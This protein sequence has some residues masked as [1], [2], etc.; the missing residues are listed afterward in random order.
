MEKIKPVINWFTDRAS[1][2]I[3][4]SDGEFKSVVKNPI[5][6]FDEVSDHCAEIGA[7]S[8]SDELFN[9]VMNGGPEPASWAEEDNDERDNWELEDNSKD[10]CLPDE[11]WQSA[12]NEI[13]YRGLQIFLGEIIFDNN[14]STVS[15]QFLLDHGRNDDDDNKSLEDAINELEPLLPE[16]AE[17]EIS[18]SIGT[19]IF[20]LRELDNDE[21]DIEKLDETLTPLTKFAE[22]AVTKISILHLAPEL[23]IKSS[24]N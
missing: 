9:Y 23:N 20:L 15:I 1:K 24:L 8:I 6:N 12:L 11:I 2:I 3:S 19:D 13:A 5:K 17:F 10:I 16:G 18:H 4:R 7:C 21:L 14:T 22:F